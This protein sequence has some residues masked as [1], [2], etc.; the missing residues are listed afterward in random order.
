M[1]F[2]LGFFSFSWPLD[3]LV[4]DEG[5][6]FTRPKH[7]K[8]SRAVKKSIAAG[9]VNNLRHVSHN[10]ATRKGKEQADWNDHRL[11]PLDHRVL[12]F[13][14]LSQI[15]RLKIMAVVMYRFETYVK[16]NALKETRSGSC[17]FEKF[18]LSCCVQNSRMLSMLGINLFLVP[19]G[20]RHR[21]G[22][23]NWKAGTRELKI[24]KASNG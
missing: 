9:F 12:T 22:G 23:W 4:E 24:S 1:D 20:R 10:T 13:L 19:F 11:W 17:F 6:F 16:E 7:L 18:R 15:L 14:I 21:N 8:T 3:R 5:L 2:L